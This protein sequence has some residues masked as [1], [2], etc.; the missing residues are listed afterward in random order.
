M[1]AITIKAQI[2]THNQN[3]SCY[4]ELENLKRQ[5]SVHLELTDNIFI[6]IILG[7]NGP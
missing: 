2:V 7:V 1:A 3:Q 6:V 5:M 4:C